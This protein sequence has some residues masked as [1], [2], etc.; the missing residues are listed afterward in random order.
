MMDFLDFSSELQ[1]EGH[2]ATP[3]GSGEGIT[4]QAWYQPEGRSEE[5]TEQVPVLH[6]TRA[7]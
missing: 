7:R 6:S 1:P 4:W 3:F 5:P 2:G